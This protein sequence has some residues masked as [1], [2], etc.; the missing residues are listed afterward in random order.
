[1]DLLTEREKE[2]ALLVTKGLS[3]KEI[4]ENLFITRKTVENHLTQV[5]QK[6]GFKSRTQLTRYILIEFSDV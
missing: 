6:L 4:A 3:N 1:M 2:I 5:Y